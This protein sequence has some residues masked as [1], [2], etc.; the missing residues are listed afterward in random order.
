MRKTLN[1]SEGQGVITFSGCSSNRITSLLKFNSGGL[2][3]DK[4]SGKKIWGFIYKFRIRVL[5]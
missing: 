2:K 1:N 4:E 5:F 3:M